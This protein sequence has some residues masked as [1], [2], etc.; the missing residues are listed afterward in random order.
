MGYQ[1][2]EMAHSSS[3]LGTTMVGGTISAFPNL[4]YVPGMKKC[5]LSPQHWVQTAADKKT[6]MGNFDDCWILFWNR[7][8]KTIPFSTMT[9]VPTFS[10]S[11]FFAHVSNICRNI[12]SLWGPILPEVDSP[13]SSWMHTSEGE[14]RDHTWRIL[15]LKMISIVAIGNKNLHYVKEDGQIYI[16]VGLLW[17]I[18]H[19]LYG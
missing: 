9:N 2:R 3:P 1:S 19:A 6:W 10:H 13:S 4:F 7:G 8:K 11:S 15:W 17:Y 5:L 18:R 14:C 12:W 16:T